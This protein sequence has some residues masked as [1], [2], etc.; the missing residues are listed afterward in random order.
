MTIAIDLGNQLI[1][2]AIH[3]LLARSGYDTVSTPEYR[4]R[5]FS[6]C[7]VEKSFLVN[8]RFI[9]QYK[10]ILSNSGGL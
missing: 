3:H 1:S 6:S 7:Q 9:N 10:I 2:E 4:I 8:S 5:V